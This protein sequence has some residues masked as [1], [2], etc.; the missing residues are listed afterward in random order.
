MRRR[1]RYEHRLRSRVTRERGCLSSLPASTS[2]LLGLRAGLDGTPLTRAEA[3]SQLGISRRAAARLE[4]SGLRE[5]H[6]ACGGG[7]GGGRSGAV[8]ARFAS[9]ANDAPDLQPADYLPMSDAPDLQ[10]PRGSVEVKGETATSSPPA[11]ETPVGAVSAAAVS[12]N[13]GNGLLVALL[14]AAGLAAL[15]ALSL[16]TLRRRGVAMETA[17]PIPVVFTPPVEPPKPV[18]PPEPAAPAPVTV[19]RP[20]PPAPASTETPRATKVARS[21]SVVASAAASF[22]VRELVRRRRRR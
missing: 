17:A 18:E 21:A 10:K 19:I 13:E 16:V 14:V 22:A 6:V 5:L 20:A 15:A 3:A 12:A 2:E 11:V 1:V 8:N 9:L 4:H 7:S